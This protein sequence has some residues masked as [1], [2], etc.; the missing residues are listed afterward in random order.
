MWP[1]W[2]S[3]HF[4]VFREGCLMFKIRLGTWPFWNLDYVLSPEGNRRRSNCCYLCFNFGLGNV[5]W[6]FKIPTFSRPFWNPE[7]VLSP[8]GN[9]RRSNCFYLCFNFG[10]GTYIGLS[11]SQLS[12]GLFETLKIFYP[13]KKTEGGPIAF[14]Y[15]LFWVWKR[16]LD[17]SFRGR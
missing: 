4:I 9:R 3:Y 6:T 5:Y 15:V 8:E 7:N 1:I 12:D 10:L 11:K 16:I 13:M 2:Y 14:T 17:L